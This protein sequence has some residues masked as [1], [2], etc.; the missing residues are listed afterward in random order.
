MDTYVHPSIHGYRRED[1]VETKQVLMERSHVLETRGRDALMD[2]L[3]RAY[4]DA[5][6]LSTEGR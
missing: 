1:F 6:A 3:Q 2:D 4:R 5:E